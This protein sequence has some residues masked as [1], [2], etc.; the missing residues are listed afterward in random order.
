M[1]MYWASKKDLHWASKMAYLT[2]CLTWVDP[3]VEQ[4]DLHWAAIKD[5]YIDSLSVGQLAYWDTILIFSKIRLFIWNKLLI[6]FPV[7]L[8]VVDDDDYY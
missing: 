6:F 2:D 3:M 5:W 4:K 8:C 1:M 7:I